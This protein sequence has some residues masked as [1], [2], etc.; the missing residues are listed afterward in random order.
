MFIWNK[1]KSLGGHL[2]ENSNKIFNKQSL[3]G[4]SIMRI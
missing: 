3:F 4:K 2:K 1:K